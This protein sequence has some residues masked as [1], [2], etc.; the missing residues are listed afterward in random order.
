[1]NASESGTEI[2]AAAVVDVDDVDDVDVAAG[3]AAGTSD[4][5]AGLPHATNA[6]ALRMQSTSRRTGER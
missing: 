1:V 5:T 4:S 6:A 2:C 3:A